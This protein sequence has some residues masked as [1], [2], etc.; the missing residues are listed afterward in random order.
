MTQLIPAYYIPIQNQAVQI[1]QK[2][3]LHSD[4][5][6]FLSAIDENISTT[7][8]SQNYFGT[9]PPEILTHVFSN[10]SEISD[11]AS[12]ARVCK[13][14]KKF[15]DNQSLWKSFC[16][17]WWRNNSIC[18]RMCVSKFEKAVKEFFSLS[19]KDWKW[20]S[21]CLSIQQQNGEAWQISNRYVATAC[22]YSTFAIKFII[23]P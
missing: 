8:N 6:A 4:W 15:A 12:V 18:K 16:L 23:V 19:G 5:A 10:L 11:V 7:S 9:L 3:H 22:R 17:N 21:M 20:L 2:L 14:W 13:D 1:H